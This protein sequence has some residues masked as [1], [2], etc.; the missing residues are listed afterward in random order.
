MADK[1]VETDEEVEKARGVPRLGGKGLIPKG[2]GAKRRLLRGVDDRLHRQYGG[3]IS[4]LSRIRGRLA[5]SKDIK[6]SNEPT[7]LEALD[8]AIEKARGLGLVE[9]ATY[10][11]GRAYFPHRQDT[12]PSL[13]G[14]KGLM[15]AKGS[16]GARSALGGYKEKKLRERGMY[17]SGIVVPRSKERVKTARKYLEGRVKRNKYR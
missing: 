8:S 14:Q 13:K 1:L 2:T 11:R 5:S 10:N 3:S 16:S 4:T 9:K 17:Y 6:K 12:S 7:A 15:G